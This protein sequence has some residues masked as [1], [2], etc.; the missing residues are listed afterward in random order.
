VCGAVIV[1]LRE[2]AREPGIL[3]LESMARRRG[4]V[5]HASLGVRNAGS[6]STRSN[7]PT[8]AF[9]GR[10]R[11]ATRPRCLARVA[12]PPTTFSR[13]ICRVGTASRKV[14]A[15]R[16]HM[17]PS[18]AVTGGGR[19]QRR[20]RR[21]GPDFSLG[22]RIAGCPIGGAWAFRRPMRGERWSVRIGP[23]IAALSDRPR[24]PLPVRCFVTSG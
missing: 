17:H 11:H 20:W 22:R 6:P 5:G 24:A 18:P 23:A 2:A 9:G 13:G 10:G 8:A 19:P 15:S 1:G 21:A 3:P 12:S 7:G 14:A 4:L 16:S